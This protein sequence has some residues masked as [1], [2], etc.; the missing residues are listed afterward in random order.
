MLCVE[1]KGYQLF[2]SVVKTVNINLNC[3]TPHSL[4]KNETHVVDKQIIIIKTLNL[5]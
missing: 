4:L 2:S 3:N 5:Q 1:Y